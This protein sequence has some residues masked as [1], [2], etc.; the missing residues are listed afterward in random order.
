MVKTSA[1]HAADQGSKPGEFP[2]QGTLLSLENS[3]T[4]ENVHGQ[5]VGAW[6]IPEKMNY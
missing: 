4:R 1:F 5:A 6:I 2:G 3:S